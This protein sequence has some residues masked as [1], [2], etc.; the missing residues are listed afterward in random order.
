MGTVP[1]AA[2]PLLIPA[3]LVAAIAGYLL[4][5]AH[6]GTAKPA[7]SRQARTQVL[8]NAGLLLEYPLGWTRSASALS[9]A[10]LRLTDGV[11]LLAPGGGDEEGLLTGR[12][13]AGEA[14]PLPAAFLATLTRQPHTEV[15][16]LTSTSAYRYTDVSPRGHA[17]AM[18]IYVIAGAGEGGPRLLACFAASAQTATRQSCE[19]IA[20]AVAP[21][22]G[23]PASIAPVGSYASTL[24]RLVG[25]LRQER[26]TLRTRMAGS[27]STAGVGELAGTLA[28]R[29]RAVGSTL[30]RIEAPQA[31][32]RA[33]QSLAGAV[34]RAGQA[35]STLAADASSGSVGAYDLARGQVEKAESEVDMALESF[36][37]LGYGPA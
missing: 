16:S 27:S 29:F 3:V 28:A 25:E 6:H 17:G 31:A 4:G 26:A 1:R 5:N 21:L 9:L 22:G 20:E 11:A 23:A 7:S 35:Y 33:Q 37:L 18:T 10:G 2:H 36:S 13:P 32:S 34:Q 15:V 14:A 12:L 30:S 19:G 8:S 24:S